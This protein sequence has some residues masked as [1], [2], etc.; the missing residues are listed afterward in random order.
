MYNHYT[1]AIEQN[2]SLNPSEWN[3]KSNPN[4]NA[5]LEHVDEGKGYE[6]LKSI[7]E[8]FH[9]IFNNN[10]NYIIDLCR[11]NDS[12]GKTN[13]VFFKNFI[14]CSPTNLRYIYH[15]LLNLKYM[16]E[17]NLNNINVIEIGGG[18]GGLCFFVLKL[19]GLFNIKINTYH[20]F[21][22][23]EAVELQKLYLTNLQVNTYSSSTLDEPFTIYGNSY[24]ISNYG[25][26]E[27]DMDT[28]KKYIDKVISPFVSNG[29]IV[30]NHIEP[31]KFINKDLKI[32]R[33][34]PLTSVVGLNVE[35][36]FVYF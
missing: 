2:L 26:S 18:Y 20:I 29:M 21:D 9:E 5:I 36:K 16:K 33:E 6:Y 10:L 32:E 7:N 34:R 22:L 35:N 31:Y 17:S 13:R 8:E 28:Q 3:F 19:A 4:Y 25:F 1:Q 27:F 12:Y 15:A 14:T 23:K 24:L 30:W 11:T